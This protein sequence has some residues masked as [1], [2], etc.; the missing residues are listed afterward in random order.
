MWLLPAITCAVQHT[1]C[2]ASQHSSRFLGPVGPAVGYSCN[3][4]NGSWCTAKAFFR[5]VP[6]LAVNF[7]TL[8][9]FLTTY[10]LLP[11]PHTCLCHHPP[12]RLRMTLSC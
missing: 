11:L 2:R 10:L 6:I 1:C 3:F 8:S 7:P 9:T 4:P 5:Y 12:P